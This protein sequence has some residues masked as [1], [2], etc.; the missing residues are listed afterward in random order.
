MI[1][2]FIANLLVS[3]SLNQ[4][5]ALI[6][7]QQLIVLMPLFKTNIPANAGM[8]FNQIME[9]AAFDIIEIGEYCDEILELEPIEPENPNFLT[10]G[11]ESVFLLNNLGTLAIAYLIWFLAAFFALLVWFGAKRSD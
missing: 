10:L 6:N 11:I 1:F 3:A 9:I 8:F 4:L 2:S 7:T 5:W